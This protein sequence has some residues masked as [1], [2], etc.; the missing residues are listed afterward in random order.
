MRA[1]QLTSEIH[2]MTAL[3]MLI[4]VL[5]IVIAIPFGMMLAPLVLGILI[6]WLGLRHVSG[7]LD[8]SDAALGAALSAAQRPV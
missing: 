6:V 4:G 3:A 7:S 8:R 5:L 2:D 1:N